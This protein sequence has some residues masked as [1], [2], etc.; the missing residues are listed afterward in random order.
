MVTWV[1]SLLT[2]W[3][4]IQ[5][6]AAAGPTSSCPTTPRRLVDFNVNYTLP[7]FQ[8]ANPIQ[9]IQ[10]N[11][12]LREVYIASQNAIEAVDR[13]LKR[14]WEVRTG[15]VGP[16][17]CHKCG[18]CDAATTPPATPV[19]TDNK[20]LLLDPAGTLLPYLY[21]CGSTRQGVCAFLDISELSP[22]SHCLF[23]EQ[24]NTETY[25]PDCLASPL[26]TRVSA[27]EQGH[28]TLFFVA[29]SVD[30]ELASRWPRRSLSVL[31]PL[32]TEDGFNMAMQG[33][34]VLPPLRASYRVDYV[35]T[36]ATE[37]HVY[38][39]S[40]QR[41]NPEKSGSPLQTR[42]G[43]LP[44]MNSEAWMYREVVLECRFD[45]K[46]R[47]RKRRGGE[48]QHRVVF[49]GLQAAHY[50]P[51]GRELASQLGLNPKGSPDEKLLY[52]AFAQ[53]DE[54]GV[55]QRNS[56]FC[57][58]ALA[59][60]NQ[61]I[62]RGVAACCSKGTEQL[63]RGLCHFQPCEN[64][65]HESTQ[66]DDSCRNKPTL[67][68]APYYRLD[69]FNRQMHDVLFTTVL[70]TTKG[71]DTLGHFGTSD[72]R[73]LQV[74]LKL[75]SVF[76]ANFS[77]GGTPVSGVSSVY[78]ED[79]LLFVAGN[80]VFT[81]SPVGPGCAHFVSC[82]SCLTAPLFMGCGWCSGSCSREDECSS[83]W[84]R[85]SCA[86]VITEFFP[87]TAPTGAE[88]E[89]TL[90][91]WD[92]QSPKGPSAITDKTHTVRVGSETLCTVQ[93]KSTSTKLVCKVRH[94]KGTPTKALNVTLE[95]QEAT[96]GGCYSI[97]GQAQ[98]SGFSF[99]VPI[100]TE[101]RPALG[102]K[103]GGTMIT[104]TGSHLNSGIGR[105]V[106]F[107][108]ISC[109]IQSMTEGS[110]SVSSVVCI[111]KKST[112]VQD[113]PVRFFIDSF[114]VPTQKKFS[115][116]HNPV[117][118]NVYPQC[119]YR[120]GSMLRV[121]GRYFDSV[122]NKV[123]QYK[124]KN[125]PQE[126]YRLVCEGK[127]NATH[128]ECRAPALP[129]E[130]SDD[131][132]ENGE[133]SFHMDG[134]RLILNKTF[135]YHPDAAPIP[136]ENEERVL[137]LSHG[138]KEVS[139]H[140]INLN[141][142]VQCMNIT[143]TIGGV[144]CKVQVLTNEL[145]CRIPKGLVIPAEGLPVQVFV[146][147][148]VTDIGN[149]VSMDK[150]SGTIIAS[151]VMGIL[152]AIVLGAALALFGMTRLRKTKQD[153]VEFRLSRMSSR[154]HT[155]NGET[156]PTGDYRRNLSI[157]TSGQGGLFFQGPWYASG[158]DP[159]VSL[160]L[161][162]QP[163]LSMG[164]LRS[165]L[166]EEVKD[167]LIPAEMLRVVESQVIG[168]GHFG[169]VYHGYLMDHKDQEIHCAV[170]SLNRISDVEEVDLFLREGIIMKGFH[171]TNIISLLG[172]MLP[173]E[174]LPLVVLPYM[175]H[176]DLRH[177][178]RSEKRNPTVKDL[179]GFGLQVAKGMEYLSQKKFVH[180]DLA[181]RNCML[182]ENFTV[183]VADFG[184]ARD[185]FDKEYYSIQDHKKAK[186]PVKWMAIESLQTQKFT[187]KSD[188]W[189]F[190]VLL[191]ELLTRG[192]TPYPDVDPY[193][194]THY[195]LKGR[196]LA[197]PQ[198]CPDALFSIMVACWEP[199]PESRP[200]FQAL[201]QIV[202]EIMEC[203]EGEHYISLKVTYVNLDAPKPYPTRADSADEAEDSD[204]GSEQ[205]LF[206]TEG[207]V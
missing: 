137:Y 13:D 157:Q 42:L 165:D 174:G 159:S 40:V 145:T 144:R 166:L 112:A 98:A 44:L 141:A 131:K 178:I 155:G 10:A 107:G 205:D 81:V 106:D 194:I 116:R 163:T 115:Y 94:K 12:Y 111:S 79:L 122:Q 80:K 200:P 190:G 171:N 197:Q 152:A 67:V 69:L 57:I 164:S 97:H 74:I 32:S 133:I 33:L 28:T 55:P 196:R 172:I 22:V 73:I 199:E 192:A 103:I 173:K 185:I 64:C 93:A 101:V 70:V 25:C 41:E 63:S 195:L 125:S 29:N 68:S 206:L 180:R 56:A 204:S 153:K 35:Y 62:D 121:E 151:I 60:V 6:H 109:P 189:S 130:H 19:D 21:Y 140:H 76:F 91:G 54:R 175:K 170:K 50:G 128:M 182:D 23:K 168:K 18:P 127:V 53:V 113:V 20:V 16:D 88:S 188:V 99:V 132:T 105:S 66:N 11:A 102:P 138:N 27:V 47:R 154:I 5:T 46:R 49:N 45:P 183:K 108:G 87:K 179:V 77:L 37:E 14:I 193:D 1:A 34:T 92:F 146:N 198:F 202:Q 136:F 120:S 61:A 161:I 123:V 124:P 84:H 39:L 95:V 100:I 181:A 48:E 114:L 135:D 177:F 150:H 59:K 139:M 9:N 117:I 110:G 36:F 26:G 96:V 158:Y 187:T 58:F 162:Q 143:M 30:E 207:P 51:V 129:G 2:V 184:M 169:T 203:L 142:V 8:T 201:V 149:V 82:S 85:T 186:L 75:D 24:D 72:G 43:R 126:T 191:W 17:D 86:P 148:K 147:G 118:T 156:S 15:P 119:S 167:V 65:P 89:L 83:P 78:T 4:L 176:G 90:C 31:R 38:F 71:N 134:A 160:S 104:L 3:A 52:G 7:H